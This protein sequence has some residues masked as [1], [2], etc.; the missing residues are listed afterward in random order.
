MSA[1]DK[2]AG[3][4]GKSAP[5]GLHNLRPATGATRRKKRIGRG[6]GS[7]HGKTAGRGNKGFWSRSGSSQKRGFEGG[8]MPLHRRVPKRGF[9][10][11]FR[12]E[13][14]EVNVDVLAARFPAGSTVGP[15][16][17]KSSRVV[18]KLLAGVKVLGRGDIG[19]ALT[20]RAH[21]VSAEARRKIEA[22][23]G[24]VEIL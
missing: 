17:L 23:G 9:T 19:H 18:R 15:E 5:L 6:P 13:F 20:I 4:T 7:G 24:K 12:K 16:E 8:Q 14:A 2:G 1:A 10:N 21:R 22:A 11:I 3:K